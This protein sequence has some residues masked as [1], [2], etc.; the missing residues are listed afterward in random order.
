[1][2]LTAGPLITTSHDP[3]TDVKTEPQEQLPKPLSPDPTHAWE[4][5]ARAECRVGEGRDWLNTPAVLIAFSMEKGR[6]KERF[7]LLLR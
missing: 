5:L 6:V 1:M 7:S 2:A 4:F 3:S